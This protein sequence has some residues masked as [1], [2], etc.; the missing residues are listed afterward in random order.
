MANQ[1]PSLGARQ[2]E[3]QAADHVI[4]SP[5]EQAHKR[6]TGV[7]LPFDGPLVVA[8]ELSFQYAVISLHL[9][10][11]PKVNA[12]IRQF[13]A[14]GGHTGRVLSAL[15]SAFGRVAASS[16]EEQLHSFPAAKSADRSSSTSHKCL[17][18][19]VDF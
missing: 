1:L 9:L 15:N 13:A 10:L 3:T 4:Q 2:A 19:T 16:L 14:A 8:A 7:S 17:R 12:V 5:L 18:S 6:L 11:L